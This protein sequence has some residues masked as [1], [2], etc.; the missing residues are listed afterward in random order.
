MLMEPESHLHN[1][2]FTVE[3]GT[4]PIHV[5]CDE[6]KIKQVFINLIK[7]GIEAMSEGG[8][9]KII[10]SIEEDDSQLVVLIRD[11]GC[12]I[13]EEDLEKLAEPF[14]T[15]KEKGNG[16]G[17]MMCYKI[18]QEHKGTICVDSKPNIG[19]TFTIKI[20]V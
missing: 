14:F 4:E 9:L 16:L 19:T 13:P 6:V 20:P 17:L 8:I 12:G 10:L 5:F 3:V 7:N 15:T 2:Q 1:V 18:I 11:H